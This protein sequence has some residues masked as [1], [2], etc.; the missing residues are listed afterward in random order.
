MRRRS[1]T[2]TKDTRATRR[3]R[4]RSEQG[5]LAMTWW[6][7]AEHKYFKMK[8][9][10]ECYAK[11]RPVVKRSECRFANRIKGI[12]GSKNRTKTVHRLYASKNYRSKRS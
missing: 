4:N 3:Y 7:K 12:K 2:K 6:Y 10:T 5:G 1:R 9:G 8:P 11:F